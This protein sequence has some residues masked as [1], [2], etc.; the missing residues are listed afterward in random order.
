MSKLEPIWQNLPLHFK[1]KC[2]QKLDYKSRCSLRK[3]SKL[4]MHIVDISPNNLNSLAINTYENYSFL[5]W[6]NDGDTVFSVKYFKNLG[7]SD[8]KIE[9][10]ASPSVYLPGK[11]QKSIFKKSIFLEN[12]DPDSDDLDFVLSDFK[13]AQKKLNCKKSIINDFI[14]KE[15]HPIAHPDRTMEFRER[16]LNQMTSSGQKNQIK[17]EILHLKWHKN[18]Q[19]IA[20]ILKMFESKNLKKLE[21][22]DR[23]ATWQMAEITKTEQW[24]KAEQLWMEVMAEDLK[25]EDF[26][27]FSEIQMHVRDL[28][29]KDLWSVIQNF[30]SKN[31]Y[32]ASFHF[33]YRQG[34]PDLQRILATFNVI[35]DDKPIRAA[36]QIR[37]ILERRIN[38]TQRFQLSNPDLILV[39]MIADKE[40]WGTVCHVANVDVEAKVETGMLR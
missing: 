6:S 1:S 2:V 34:E 32:G 3:C 28:E 29:E 17:T 39:V 26:R 36:T 35:P 12:L 25:I 4:D 11:N 10:S 30:R 23:N 38:H 7:E 24:I 20:E 18:P 5:S 19:E 40:V 15:Y 16:L 33:T 13:I 37:S 9:F 27:H 21:F 31:R 8:M 14:L 22:S